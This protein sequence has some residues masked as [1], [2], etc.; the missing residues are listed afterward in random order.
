MAQAREIGKVV[1]TPPNSG[2]QKAAHV[3]THA[4]Q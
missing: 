3:E 4:R 1:N 2:K